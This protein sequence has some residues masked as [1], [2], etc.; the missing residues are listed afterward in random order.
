MAIALDFLFLFSSHLPK[1]ALPGRNAELHQSFPKLLTVQ[2]HVF[3]FEGLS[4]IL[5]FAEE[6]NKVLVQESPSATER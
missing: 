2:V 1:S 5:F 6:I 4:V 3:S